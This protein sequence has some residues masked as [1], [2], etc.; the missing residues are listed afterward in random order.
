[1]YVA[2]WKMDRCSVCRKAI[3]NNTMSI[4]CCI[5]HENCHYSAV[6]ESCPYRKKCMWQCLNYLQELFPFNHYYENDDFIDGIVEAWHMPRDVHLTEL[7]ENFFIP[8]D[9]SEPSLDKHPLYDLNPDINYYGQISNNIKNVTIIL[10]KHSIGD[11]K[12]ALETHK[13]QCQCCI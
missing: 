13:I 2:Y 4:Q 1:M 11:V 3:R 10:G 7:R 5:C 8:F 6:H 9:T 12:Q